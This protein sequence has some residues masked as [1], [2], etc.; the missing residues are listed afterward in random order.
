MR[1]KLSDE[2]N[3]SDWFYLAD[4]RLHAADWIELRDA[5]P[6]D[7]GTCSPDPILVAATVSST[8]FPGGASGQ[9]QKLKH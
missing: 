2:T 9:K 8:G 6:T 3:P 5:A 4:D 7:R 1:R